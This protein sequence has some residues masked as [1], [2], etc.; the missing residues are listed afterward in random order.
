MSASQMGIPA[1]TESIH[2]A[3]ALEFSA[4]HQL[5]YQSIQAAVVSTIGVDM[6]LDSGSILQVVGVLHGNE[7]RGDT[8]HVR[9]AIGTHGLCPFDTNSSLVGLGAVVCQINDVIVVLLHR[10]AP[11]SGTLEQR[12]G[13]KRS[14]FK[15]FICQH[16]RKL[17]T[18][19]GLNCVSKTG[20]AG[21]GFRRAIQDTL[22]GR[23][24]GQNSLLLLTQ[25][26]RLIR[27][28]VTP[29]LCSS[30]PR[31]GSAYSFFVASKLF[32]VLH[33]NC[34][35]YA[36]KRSITQMETELTPF[37]QRFLRIDTCNLTRCG[38]T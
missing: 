8:V 31:M 15:A 25:R 32:R 29:S 2:R 13:R 18:N 21:I 14:N 9:G 37:I 16:F 20:V 12:R 27:N 34:L 35:N 36:I 28:L 33:R 17:S 30:Q 26:N 1:A 7:N 5:L 24:Q 11:G 10:I 23:V 38:V 4:T 19:T 3:L 6:R 22:L